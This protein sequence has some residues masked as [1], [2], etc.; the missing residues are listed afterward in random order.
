[1]AKS[2]TWSTSM[3]FIEPEHTHDICA[4]CQNAKQKDY[5]IYCIHCVCSVPDCNELIV[6][7]GLCQ[8][9]HLST[10]GSFAMRCPCDNIFCWTCIV[11]FDIWKKIQIKNFKKNVI[12][13]K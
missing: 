8:D 12:Y 10:T 3:D 2:V 1:M 7:H 13:V 5:F 11:Q 4:N 9:C 6:R